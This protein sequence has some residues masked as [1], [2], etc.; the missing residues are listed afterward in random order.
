MTGP[1][2]ADLVAAYRATIVTIQGDEP[3]VV[4][5]TDPIGTHD[6]WLA[7]QGSTSA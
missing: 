3:F 6:R 5:M 2:S 7:E 1:I 4:S